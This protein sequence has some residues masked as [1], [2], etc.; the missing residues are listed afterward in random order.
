MKKVVIFL[1]TCFSFLISINASVYTC[2]ITGESEMYSYDEKRSDFFYIVN[3]KINI[4][5]IEE[6]STF[7]LHIAYD[8]DLYGTYGC[9]FLNKAFSDC[10]INKNSKEIYY[11]YNYSSKNDLNNDLYTARFISNYKTPSEG[12][13][14]IKVYFDSAKDKQGNKVSIEE[15]YKT[16]TF[17]DLE[18]YFVPSEVKEV[19]EDS[20]VSSYI[21]TLKIKGYN[22]DF[23]S[24][25]FEY[26]LHVKS[27]VNKLDISLELYDSNASYLIK[28]ASD[29]NSF[30]NK[31]IILVKS[32]DN[33]ETE[34]KINVVREKEE[35][36]KTSI[37][38]EVKN[39]FSKNNIKKYLPIVI[40]I[41]LI[42]IIIIFVIKKIS[43]KKIDKFLDEI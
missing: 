43:S 13:S 41:L 32:S 40:G 31:V 21:K 1:I 7:K 4:N 42:I 23:D 19:N 10:T 27:D 16:I 30:G 9:S 12:E 38:E 5:H 34:Y 20:E 3:E 28:G 2:N 29:L 26:N 11:T 14:V 35:I 33:D 39:I 6:L 36:E 17:K 25:T 24:E 15:C 8:N 37:K 22:L 18:G